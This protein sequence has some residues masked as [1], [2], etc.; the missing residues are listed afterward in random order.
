MGEVYR[1]TDTAL[2][3]SVAVKVLADRYA[4]QDEA[5]ARFRREALAAARLSAAPNVVTVFDVAEH[6]GRPLIVM[7]YLE[8]GSVYDRLR[9]G[10]IPRDQA[11]TWLAQTAE[12]LDRAHAN[13]IVHRDVKPANLLLDR[14][15][16]VHVS[17]FGIAS[18]SGSDMLTE[19]GT[20][21]G[22]AGYIS[23]EQA[24]GE[25]AT[26][27]SDRYALGVVAFELLTGRRPFSGDTP[28]TEAFAHLHASIPRAVEVDPT[29]PPALD[30]VFESALAKDPAARPA[31]AR[32]LVE[33]LQDALA[34]PAV[35]KPAPTRVAPPTRRRTPPITSRLDRRDHHARPS[36]ARLAVL[37]AILV[38]AL[39]LA[40]AA[41]ATTGD[42]TGSPQTRPQTRRTSTQP[43]AEE[44]REAP[45]V[46]G[47]ALG[48]DGFARMQ[49]GD[50]AAALPLL[51]QAVVALRGSN[52][53]DEAYSSYNLAFTRFAVGRCDGVTALLDRSERIQGHRKE[54]DEL[55]RQWE[56]RCGHS[57]DESREG[58]ATGTKGKG[59]GKAKG[60]HENG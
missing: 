29:L 23:P 31:T 56:S 34:T 5:R 3:R 19:P 9:A 20:V 51:R 10:R 35:P 38:L 13:G 49:A 28:T 40:I 50:Y 14:E 45:S 55:R 48:R 7:E 12:A 4:R 1:A 59:H 32:E 2:E 16:N 53:L 46:D 39:G 43:P 42:D 52:T 33:R 6:D 27:A 11:L 15:G 25:P 44:T 17:D 58:Q 22:T 37:G 36:R 30:E 21:L 24:R 26:P 41:I 60:R 57:G 47:A 8:G 54:I 18:A